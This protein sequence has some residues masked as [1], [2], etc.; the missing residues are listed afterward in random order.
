M[1]R[2]N[3][4]TGEYISIRFDYEDVDQMGNIISNTAFK[5]MFINHPN[6]ELARKAK[7]ILYRMRSYVTAT[8]QNED[9]SVLLNQ[10][11]FITLNI[12]NGFKNVAEVYFIAKEMKR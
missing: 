2:Y 11:T 3:Q 10:D 8:P 1:K 5:N 4:K 7:Q 6:Q 9:N 12:T